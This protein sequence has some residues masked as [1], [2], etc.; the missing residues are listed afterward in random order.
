MLLLFLFC[1]FSLKKRGYRPNNSVQIDY[2][3]K[4]KDVMDNHSKDKLPDKS[5]DSEEM[6]DL[7]SPSSAQFDQ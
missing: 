6:G 5:V 1:L 4:G 3:E 7:S 2:L